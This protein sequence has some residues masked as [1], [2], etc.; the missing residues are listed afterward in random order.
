LDSTLNPFLFHFRFL[1][2]GGLS[3]HDKLFLFKENLNMGMLVIWIDSYEE[4]YDLLEKSLSL[5]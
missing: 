4:T 5:A 2:D 1:L 3:D